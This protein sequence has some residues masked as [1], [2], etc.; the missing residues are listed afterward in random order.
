MKILSSTT[1]DKLTY[2][3][4]TTINNKQPQQLGLGILLPI[5]KH[6]KTKKVENR[7][8]I[9]LST[10][11]KI[12]SLITLN[13]LRP[14]IENYLSSSQAAYRKG[15]SIEDI[16][17]TL[18][19]EIASTLS[20][21]N[22]ITIHGI[23]L[24]SAFDSV[25]RVKMIEILNTICSEEDMKL[26]H[27]LLNNTSLRVRTKEVGPTFDTNIGIPQG[28]GLSP[29]L[30]TTYLEAALREVRNNVHAQD[31]TY[32]DDVDFI[33]KDGV[34]L[35]IVEK[36]LEKWNLKMN[37]TK[38]ET[39]KIGSDNEW[40]NEKKLGMLLDTKQEWKRRKQ[41]TTT[42]MLKL[43]KNMEL[44]HNKKQKVKNLQSLRLK[45]HAFWL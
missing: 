45:H 19:L 31:I 11:R 22:K 29:V 6:N 30:F 16:V 37:P 24:S 36:I 7:P 38:T 28:N 13:R 20:T 40:K 44:E 42:A 32:A 25:N 39:L 23:D 43:K 14:T 3:I 21:N 33:S 8:I 34:N 26:T 10:I 41:L 5:P 2:I 35:N 18:K 12:I 15:R 17:W 1:I 27:C 9:L 4:N